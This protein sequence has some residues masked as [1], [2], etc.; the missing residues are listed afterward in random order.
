[1]FTSTIGANTLSRAL[2]R[3]LGA[4]IAAW[5]AIAL[6]TELLARFAMA[7]FWESWLPSAGALAAPAPV[8][9]FASIAGFA[10]GLL[11]GLIFRTHPV[12]VAAYAGSLAAVF[13]LLGGVSL[14]W[15][16]SSIGLVGSYP[17]IVDTGFR[18]WSFLQRPAGCR[19]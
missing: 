2:V 7:R 15:V 17:R 11:L 3:L 5:C 13:M 8:V 12:R 18:G 10:F 16:T 1:M 9:L 4:A 6:S 14:A 19:S